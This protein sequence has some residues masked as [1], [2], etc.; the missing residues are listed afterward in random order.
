MII[1][2]LISRNEELELFLELL[3][4]E[5]FMYKRVYIYI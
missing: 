1:G 3:F 4:S 5:I 2:L